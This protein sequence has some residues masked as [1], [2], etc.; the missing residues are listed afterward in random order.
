M[1]WGT[2]IGEALRIVTDWLLNP[3]RKAKKLE[4]QKQEAFEKVQEIAHGDDE[5]AMQDHIGNLPH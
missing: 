3:K 1:G 4:D 2:A 5:K